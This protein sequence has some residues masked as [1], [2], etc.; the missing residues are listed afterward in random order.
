M[1][2]WAATVITN[3]LSAIPYIGVMLVEWV[4]GGFSVGGPTL[5]RFFSFHFL[6]PLIIVV[7]VLLHLVFLHEGG[8]SD[9]LGLGRDM[10]KIVFHPYYVWRDVVGFVI[11]LGVLFF[12]CLRCPFVF[13]DVEN[14]IPANSIVTP[15]HIQ[16]AWYFLFAYA[17]L[18]SVPRRVGGVLALGASVFVLYLLPFFNRV[19]LRGVSLRSMRWVF[20][21]FVS[22]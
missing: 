19:V 9:F 5:I 11:G 18:R 22:I 16:P 4:W 14:F 1:S 21:I 17:I 8:S 12:V 6:F 7:L 10:D 3:L 15:V 20:W 13:I 2:F